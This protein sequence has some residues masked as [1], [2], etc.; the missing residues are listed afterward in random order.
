MRGAR[1]LACPSERAASS[2]PCPGRGTPWTAFHAAPPRQQR[3][4]AL[5]VSAD[6]FL[7]NR[8]QQIV[9][10]AARDAIPAMYF[11]R[12]FAADGGLMSYG[13]DI[14]DAYRRAGLYVG[15][16]LKGEKPADLPV[17][18]ATKFEFVINLGTAKA[19]GLVGLGGEA[20]CIDGYWVCLCFC[21]SLCLGF[22][23]FHHITRGPVAVLKSFRGRI[24]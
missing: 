1:P 14:A 24:G 10:L 9:T 3:A 19:L 8:R 22:F 7:S 21:E 18:Q 13:N 2:I 17:D 11:N 20:L 4:D 12:E 23:C 6:P 15:R 5:L 16:I